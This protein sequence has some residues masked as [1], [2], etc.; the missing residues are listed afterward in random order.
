M[1]ETEVIEGAQ[2]CVVQWFVVLDLLEIE[3]DHHRGSEIG[4][5]PL[6]ASQ[7][8]WKI[9]ETRSNVCFLPPGCNDLL[10]FL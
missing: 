9:S 10:H 2:A 1:V 5:C 8:R 4:N 3:A 6:G 7:P